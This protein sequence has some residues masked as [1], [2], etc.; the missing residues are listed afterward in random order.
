MEKNCFT[1]PC[2][3]WYVRR[4]SPDR[5]D[6]NTRRRNGFRRGGLCRSRLRAETADLT[7]RR[8]VHRTGRRR[9]F[10]A[11]LTVGT[12][13]AAA[14]GLRRR[15]GR[16]P[17]GPCRS[18]LVRGGTRRPGVCPGVGGRNSRAAE[19]T[20]THPGGEHTG[21]QP[22]ANRRHRTLSVAACPSGG[23]RTP[24]RPE[25]RGNPGPFGATRRLD[26]LL[27]SATCPRA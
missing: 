21:H 14:A 27:G 16:D 6:F 1:L 3:H 23:P 12:R 10:L 20:A 8:G 24:R 13:T 19:Q 4:T 25:G 9:V 17:L 2:F 7:G 18:R 22:H 5:Q 11:G 15:S 26:G